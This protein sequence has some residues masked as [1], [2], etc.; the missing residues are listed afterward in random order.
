MVFADITKKEQTMSH[1]KHLSI[2]ERESL[3]LYLNCGKSIRKIAKELGRSPSTISREIARNKPSHRPYSPSAAQRRYEHCKKKCGRKAIVSNND[4]RELLRKLIGENEWSPEQIENRLRLEHN[5][6]QVSYST[7]YRALKNCLLEDGDKRHI[8]KCDRLSFHLR[9]KGTPRKKNGKV[10]RQ[11]R[12][13]VEYTISQRP[14]AANDRTELGHW[15]ADTVA[16]KRGGAH[17]L[18]QVDRKARFLMAIKIPDATA[19][20]VKEAMIT[21]FRPLPPEKRKSVTPD[22]GHEFTKYAEVSEAV[23]GLPFYFADPYSPWQRGTN[24]NTNGL[25]RQYYPKYSDLTD[26]SPENL[27]EVVDKINHRPRKCLGWLSPYE[28]FYNTLL[29]L[30]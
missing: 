10:N 6:L 18:T 13:E 22:R 25:L 12:I 16:G 17:L 21:M 8:R 28:V 24:E 20:T 26:L 3:Y 5:R 23:D 7:I 9:R 29:H 14:A 1:Y 19:E 30:T 15:E 27:A 2:E 4:N 11:G